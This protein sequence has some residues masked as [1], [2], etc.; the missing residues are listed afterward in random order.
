MHPCVWV[1]RGRAE[2]EEEQAHSP[3]SVELHGEAPSQDS[4]ILT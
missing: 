3:L 2:E 1:G 4:V